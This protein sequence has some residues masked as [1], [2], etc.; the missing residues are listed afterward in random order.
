MGKDKEVTKIKDKGVCFCFTDFS[1]KNI[2]A[3]YKLVYQE[4]E[5][6]IRGIAWGIEKCPKTG[7]PHNQGFIQLFKQGRYGMIQRWFKSK[8]HFEVMM[9]SIKN[10]EEYCSKENRYTIYGQFVE[11]GYRTDLHNIKDDIKQGSGMYE[12]MNNYTGDFIRYHSGIDKMKQVI[13]KKKDHRSVIDY[14]K[15]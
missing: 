1:V 7:K 3:G 14:Q 6:M 2:E 9:G 8:C 10:N 4:Y 15:R 12:I 5:D 13:D 11:Q